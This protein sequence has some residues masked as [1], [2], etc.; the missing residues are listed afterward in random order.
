MSDITKIQWCD[1]TV[2]P[3]M[4]CGGCELFPSSG[5][6]L[7]AIDQAVAATGSRIDKGID[8]VILGGESGS[9]E[10]TR[11][12][13]LEWV[14]ELRKHC[15]KSGVA[16]FL[17]QL[18]RNPTRNGEIFSL[19]D[20]HGGNWDEWDA[21]LRIR[22]FPKAFHDYRKDEM[23][24]SDEPR[25]IQKKKRKKPGVPEDLSIT[26]EEK[27]E[28]KRQHMIV[29]N[30]VK[31]FWQVGQALAVIKARNLWRAGGHK[32][33]D[34]YCRSVAGMSRGHA[35]RLM[36]AA[37]FLEILKTSPR[38]DVLPEMEA[39]VRPLL[40]LSEPEQQV[41]AWNRAVEIAGG[42][43]PSGPQARQAVLEI[44]NPG[45][46]VPTPSPRAQRI[47]LI[48]RIK[49]IIQHEQS[50]KDAAKLLVELEKLL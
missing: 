11:P 20:K 1:T 34:A 14:E 36:G 19:K 50:W 21:S 42:G 7:E 30:G 29:E 25:P 46:L 28:F 12:F 8:W 27:A 13:A 24:I 4:G 44:Q 39:Q 40:R 49:E 23:T 33:W 31:A 47:E 35:H 22:E 17:K 6:V 48:R 18:G 15:R 41:T 2:N 26:P 16:F 32:S 37:G 45:G 43:Q 9:G 3:I 10:F 5:K 38:G